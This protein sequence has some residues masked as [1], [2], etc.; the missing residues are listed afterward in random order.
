MMGWGREWGGEVEGEG[1]GVEGC[2]G[3]RDW[4]VRGEGYGRGLCGEKEGTL[5]GEE[6]VRRKKVEVE[7]WGRRKEE[8]GGG[9]SVG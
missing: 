5:C 2:G 8:G 1:R 9:G 4:V 3:G 6:W 7:V